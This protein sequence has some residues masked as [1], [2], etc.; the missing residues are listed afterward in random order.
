MSK[1]KTKRELILE[2]EKT[3][4]LFINEFKD[5]SEMQK[6]AVVEGIDRTTLLK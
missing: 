2:I 1:Y 4:N 5:L 3:S 6:D